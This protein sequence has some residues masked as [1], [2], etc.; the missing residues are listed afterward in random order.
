VILAAEVISAEAAI[1]AVAAET[2]VAAAIFERPLRMVSKERMVAMLSPLSCVFVCLCVLALT[3]DARAESRPASIRDDAGVFHADAIARAEQGVADIRRTF[4]RNLFVQT[5]ASVTPQQ[6]HWFPFLRTPQVNRMLEEQARQFADKSDV[7][8]IYVVIC[9]HPRDVHVIV[10]PNDEAGFNR[11]EAEA[12]RRMLARRLPDN[13]DAALLAAVDQVRD[14]L[15][16]HA[17][18]GSSSIVNDVVLVAVLGGGFLLWFLLALVRLKMRARQSAMPSEEETRLRPALLGS[19]FGCPAGFWIY[20]KLYPSLPDV[21]EPPALSPDE[22]E[23]DQMDIPSTLS[24]EHM[25]DL[26]V[27]P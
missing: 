16:D 23:K 17:K 13:A 14:T 8:G 26:P 19:L 21:V 7:P 5:V 27:S 2:S 15:Q 18:N 6:R 24:P 9:R 11:H 22:D 12:L 10:W 20:D 4:D 1:L 25:D 3:S